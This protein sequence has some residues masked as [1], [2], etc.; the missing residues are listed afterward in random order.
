LA[1]HFVDSGPFALALSTLRTVEVPNVDTSAAPLVR[2][3]KG[4]LTLPT[5]RS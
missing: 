5:R 3:T 4:T 1:V 2:S